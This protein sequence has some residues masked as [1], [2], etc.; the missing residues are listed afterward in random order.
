MEGKGKIDYFSKARE[1]ASKKIKNGPEEDV[2]EGRV[3]PA[4]ASNEL[5][6]AVFLDSSFKE[7]LLD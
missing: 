3:L 2:R 5:S 1:K 4:Q 6:S 7:K